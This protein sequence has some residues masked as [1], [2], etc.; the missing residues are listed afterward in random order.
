MSAT[1]VYPP[2]STA[3]P[4]TNTPSNFDSVI[5]ILKHEQAGL[6]VE[7]LSLRLGLEKQVLRRIFRVD[8]GKTF[9]KNGTTGI[10]ADLWRLV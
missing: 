6:T 10:R 5:A 1:R 4:K 9:V 8:A 7:A 2:Y 3:K